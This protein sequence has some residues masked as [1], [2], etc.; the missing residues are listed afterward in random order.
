[1]NRIFT[2]I[3]SSVAMV[4]PLSVMAEDGVYQ[5]PNGDFEM[6]WTSESEPGNGFH[7]FDLAIGNYKGQVNGHTKEQ[8]QKVEGHNSESACMIS[9][10]QFKALGLITVKANG[11]LTSGVVV[12]GAT[13]ATAKG[14]H[15]ESQIGTAN[16]H[17]KLAGLPDSISFYTKFERGEDGTYGANANFIIH[18]PVN[19]IDTYQ[20]EYDKSNKTNWVGDYLTA[21][22]KFPI[23][24]SEDW[25]RNV[26]AVSYKEPNVSYTDRY[27]LVS[28]STNPTPGATMKDHLTIDDVELIYNSS[29]LSVKL[30]G[31]EV[32]GFDKGTYMYDVDAPYDELMAVEYTTDAKAATVTKTF[33]SGNN[34]LTILVEGND[35]SVNPA[36]KHE[37]VFKFKAGAELLKTAEYTDNVIS[38]I[39]GNITNT[40]D[41]KAVVNFFDNGSCSIVLK[42]LTIGSVNVGDV[43]VSASYTTFEDSIRFSGESKVVLGG[44]YAMMGAVPV[45]VSGTSSLDY[46]KMQALMNIQV[47][48]AIV[49]D[50]QYGYEYVAPVVLVKSY[51][52]SACA[53][54][55][56]VRLDEEIQASVEIYSNNTVDVRLDDKVCAGFEWTSDDNDTYFITADNNAINIKYVASASTILFEGPKDTIE[57]GT[58]VIPRIEKTAVY[59]DY[60]VPNCGTGYIKPYQTSVKVDYYNIGVANIALAV[61]EGDTLFY[62]NIPYTKG[63]SLF[64]VKDGAVNGASTLTYFK[65]VAEFVGGDCTYS[66]GTYNDENHRRTVIDSK[67][68]TDNLLITINGESQPV[69]KQLVRTDFYDDETVNFSIK[70]FTLDGQ[71]LGDIVMDSLSY[72]ISGDSIHVSG[73]RTTS[74]VSDNVEAIGEFFPEM[75][76]ELKDAAISTAYD[77]MT[78]NLTIDLTKTTLKQMVGVAFGYR[79]LVKSA[80]YTDTFVLSVNGEESD[81]TKETITVDYY[82]NGE[83]KLS[84]LN[85]SIGGDLVGDIVLDGVNYTVSEDSIRISGSKST[86][87]TSSNPDAMGPSLGEIPIVIRASASSLDYSKLTAV[88]DIDMQKLLSESIVLKFGYYVAPKVQLLKTAEFSDTLIVSVNGESNA[89]MAQPVSVDFY[90]NNYATLSI[91]NFSFGGSL[92]GD[93]VLDSIVY[94]IEKDSIRLSGSRNINITSDNPEALGTGLGLVPVKIVSA[95]S[96]KSYDKL[97]MKIQIDMTSSLNQMV[98]VTFGISPVAPEIPVE[99]VTPVKES[100]YKDN[101]NVYRDGV[102]ED[103]YIA[104]VNIK[105]YSDNYATVLFRDFACSGQ[106]IGDIKLDSV[107]YK[108]VSDSVY[109]SGTRL[110]SITSANP[111]AVGTDFGKVKVS[112]S[113]VADKSMTEFV[114]KL[115]LDL[116]SLLK[117]TLVGEFGE[118]AVV[119]IEPVDK[120]VAYTDLLQ[121][122]VN[123]NSTAPQ[124]QTINVDY[125]SDGTCTLSI[126]NFTL[127]SDDE[128]VLVGDIVLDGMTYTVDNDSI[129]ISGKKSIAITSDDPDALG[130]DL[131]KVPVSIYSASSTLNYKQLKAVI[132]IDMQQTLAQIINVTFGYAKEQGGDKFTPGKAV[133]TDSLVVSVDGSRAPAQ[134]TDII[135]DYATDGTCTLSILNFTMGSGDEAIEVGDIIV[136]GIPYT[137]DNDSVRLSGEKSITIDSEMGAMLGEIPVK[138]NHVSSSLDKRKL[139]AYIGIDMSESIGQVVDVEFGNTNLNTSPVL[140]FTPGTAVYTDSLVVSVDGNSAPAQLTDIV[141]DYAEDGTCTLSIKNFVMGSGD[142]AIEVGDIVVP[143]ITYTVDNDSVRLSGEKSITIDSEMG[144]MLG[145]IPVS[146]TH[147]SSSLDK[148]KL[149]ALIDIDMSGSIGQVVGVQF[150]YTD[151]NTGGGDIPSVPIV[152]D[153]VS[154]TDSIYIYVN[155]SNCSSSIGKISVVFY[156]NNTADVMI[157]DF[158]TVDEFGTTLLGDA[159]VKGVKFSQVGDSIFFSKTV[160]SVKFTSDNEDAVGSYMGTVSCQFTSGVTDL[161]KTKLMAKY[162]FWLPNSD[163]A[164]SFGYENAT[165]L[166]IVVSEDENDGDVYSASGMY[167]GK[168]TDLNSLPNGLYIKNGRKYLIRK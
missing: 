69:F 62:E 94:I 132:D 27:L 61:S 19:Y 128:S 103:D 60:I 2:H 36:N 58:C 48:S 84:I 53:I 89:P 79:D 31:T 42:D 85:F 97:V 114:G 106:L 78:A 96:S 90:D 41:M 167:I 24:V 148:R 56:G 147:V 68:F 122:S 105:Y 151:L 83:A 153:S 144:A 117:Q 157:H 163:V 12:A 131:G 93:I 55:N 113:G 164:V 140:T 5:I 73:V 112:V 91:R 29:L 80:K 71:L 47:S 88:I 64:L 11:N 8:V 81:A 102:L 21:E 33:D 66:F 120:S 9:S 39:G 52:G 98:D 100:D 70:D 28:F 49:V 127:I 111:D 76:I 110:V 63:D 133:Y 92:I 37:Y 25:V 159:L 115:T 143:G 16:Q 136:P 129:R 87:I 3:L 158:S 75:D 130:P 118:P 4:A 101:M 23:G 104:D 126:P 51:S 14:N 145:E 40:E 17:L 99:V 165:G 34:T 142:E 82:D 67:E 161:N 46:S 26:Q 13:S 137:V 109:I 121:V 156:S 18:G 146:L 135:V 119:P 72:T 162:D 7:S 50:L 65:L 123:G 108:T 155:E 10:I 138:L 134:L 141:V 30:G 20:A 150:G 139:V 54:R 15:N 59:N 57:Y 35:I 160:A 168:N 116:Q 43:A 38:N 152:V 166:E 77:K 45:K 154:Y 44:S 6:P 86:V 22:N 74:F 32:A 125:K 1:M 124:R 149:T 95:A 107:S